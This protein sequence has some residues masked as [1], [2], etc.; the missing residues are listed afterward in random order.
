MQSTQDSQGAPGAPATRPRPPADATGARPDDAAIARARETL[1]RL[2]G[3]V[4]RVIVG[5]REVIDRLLIA[6]LAEGH[7]LIEDVPG[8][9]KTKLARSLSLALG[10]DFHRIQFTPDL[11]PS[12]VTG[13]LVFDQRTASFTYH[14]GPVF[15]NVVLADEI[16]RAGPRTQAALLE[17]MEERQVSVERETYPLPR[18]FLVIATQNPVELEGTFP[19]PEAQLDRFLLSTAVGYPERDDERDI[20]RRFRG[21]DPLTRLEAVTTPQEVAGLI[22]LVRGIYIG[23]AVE[24]YLLDLVRG[25][26][27]HE[28]VELGASPRAALALARAAQGSA[29]LAGRGFVIPDDV[30]AM[31]MPVLAHRII[32]SARVEL[33]GRTKAAI[34]AELVASVPVPVEA[35]VEPVERGA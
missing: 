32:P 29:V 35:D 26:R 8:I 9:G 16:N 27:E 19:L 14:P 3:E 4:E 7:V 15:A 2:R 5:K 33:R 30:R 18:P 34:L 11:L 25:T 12:D 1:G 24:D 10:G 6:M 21:D 22:G 20:L 23:E 31:A 28:E 13:S 17:A